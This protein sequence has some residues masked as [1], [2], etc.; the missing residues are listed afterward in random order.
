MAAFSFYYF[1]NSLSLLSLS[2]SSAAAGEGGRGG[3]HPGVEERGWAQCPLEA[4]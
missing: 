2:G 4:E 3:K 1:I